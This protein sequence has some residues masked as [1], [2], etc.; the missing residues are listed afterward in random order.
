MENSDL[1]KD[2]PVIDS[3]FNLLDIKDILSESPKLFLYFSQNNC[4]PCIEYALTE[5]SNLSISEIKECV[6]ILANVENP[7]EYSILLDNYNYKGMVYFINEMPLNCGKLDEKPFF[8]ILTNNF[9]PHLIFVP[10]K[11]I[12]EFSECYFQTIEEILNSR[13][14]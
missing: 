4:L 12:P 3:C 6:Y 13:S 7:R 10:E 1:K 11:T 9:N 5:I 2:L 14:P 8:F